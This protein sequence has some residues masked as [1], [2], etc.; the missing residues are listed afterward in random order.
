M[1][2]KRHN[3]GATLRCGCGKKESGLACRECDGG[4]LLPYWCETCKKPVPEKRCPSCGL[5][6][7]KVRQP[8]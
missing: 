6:C 5:K 4:M 3:T 2:H 1:D 8:G 7:R